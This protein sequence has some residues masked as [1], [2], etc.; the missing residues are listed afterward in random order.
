MAVALVQG[1]SNSAAD[2]SPTVTFGST[3]TANNLLLLQLNINGNETVSA[4]PSGF[5]IAGSQTDANGNQA[6]LYYKVASGSE[7]ALT[8][9]L[10]ASAQ[11]WAVGGTE[12][13]GCSGSL[14]TNGFASQQSNGTANPS[15]GATTGTAA[16]GDLV[17]GGIQSSS[18]NASIAAGSGFTALTLTPATGFA[19]GTAFGELGFSE[20]RTNV[21]GAATAT[22]SMVDVGNW[23]PYVA[24]FPASGGAARG[25][26]RIPSQSGLGIGGSFFRDPL[27]RSIQ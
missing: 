25:L 26:F 27:Q 22:F 5:T 20:Y 18:M 7:A 12:W 3:P 16:S 13:S 24:I 15:S 19:W 9:T 2:N 6:K 23:G 10:S 8:F 1:I 17:Y 11:W 14:A 4:V 21:S